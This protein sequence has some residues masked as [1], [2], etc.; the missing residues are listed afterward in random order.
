MF[1][2]TWL[3]SS[4][5]S[6]EILCNKFNIFRRDRLSYG[7]GVLIAVSNNMT[8]E[9]FFENLPF[10]IEFISVVININYKRIFIT[11][12]YIPPSSPISVYIQ[13][14]EAI[15]IV[16]Q[17]MNENDTLIVMG[18][19]N[20]PSISWNYSDDDGYYVQTTA[21]ESVKDFLNMLYDLSLVQING[22]QNEFSRILDLVFVNDKEDFLVTRS[23]PIT[24]P[25]DKYHPAI[26]LLFQNKPMIL[27]HL[28]IQ[29]LHL[30]SNVVTTL[31]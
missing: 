17:S 16:A 12:S 22:V 31:C 7:G 10:D 29:K 5:L 25:E 20:M 21:N 13:H 6:T 8:T 2:E 30:S 3:N 27:F 4:Y 18:D 19:F 14:G 28:S 11:C 15:Q 23:D 1:T 9:A 26:E 24:V